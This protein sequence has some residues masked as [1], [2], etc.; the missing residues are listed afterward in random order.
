MT[1][2]E[3]LVVNLLPKVLSAEQSYLI[4][5][6]K[7]MHKQEIINAVNS[8]SVECEHYDNHKWNYENGEQYYQETFKKH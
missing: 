4:E 7:R 3:W 8:I 2:I 6:A 5:K 1:S